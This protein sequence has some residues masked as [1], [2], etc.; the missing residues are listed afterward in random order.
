MIFLTHRRIV[1]EYE[2]TIAQMIGEFMLNTSFSMLTEPS[3]RSQ[4]TG[5]SVSIVHINFI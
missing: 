5:P 3:H 1:A 2:K 4:V